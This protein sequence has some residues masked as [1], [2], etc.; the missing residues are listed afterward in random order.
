MF[1]PTKLIN[2]FEDSSVRYSEDK[3][4]SNKI[5]KFIQDNM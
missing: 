5:K 2:K 4:T 1:R 3:I